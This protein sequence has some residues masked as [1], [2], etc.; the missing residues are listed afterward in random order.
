MKRYI[1]SNIDPHAD[2]RL[3]IDVYPVEDIEEVEEELVEGASKSKKKRRTANT[4]QVFRD[5]DRVINDI[6]DYLNRKGVKLIKYHKSIHEESDSTYYDV[7]IRV[8]T[9]KGPKYL[10][11]R[12]AAHDEAFDFSGS[13]DSYFTRKTSEYEGAELTDEQAKKLYKYC[14]IVVSGVAYNTYDKAINDVKM[15]IDRELAAYGIE[16]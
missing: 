13:R 14:N 4:R 7:D 2:E 5:T 12:V 8:A 1:K 15:H 3:V 6:I 16:D 10:Y 9:D 11:F